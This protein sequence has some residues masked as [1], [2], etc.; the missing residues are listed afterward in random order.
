MA[1]SNSAGLLN[2]QIRYKEIAERH[3]TYRFAIVA[4]AAV[5]GL[6][7]V[8]YGVTHMESRWYETLISAIFGA[9]VPNALARLGIS[10]KIKDAF[11]SMGTRM[12]SLELKIDPTRSTSGLKRDGNSP[13]EKP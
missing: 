2:A 13:L 10:V 5:A 1:K 9:S 3:K 12:A 6:G 4:V 7:L 11:A 8:V